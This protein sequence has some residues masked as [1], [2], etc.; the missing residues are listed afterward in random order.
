MILSS[1]ANGQN[2]VTIAL[3]DAARVDAWMDANIATRGLEELRRL[4]AFYSDVQQNSRLIFCA[5]AG[6][7]FLGHIT[8]QNHSEYAAFRRCNIPEIVDLW[9]QPDAR[10]RGVGRL[11]LEKLCDHAKAKAAQTI[12]LAVGVTSDFGAAHRLYN[13]HGFRPDGSGLWVQGKNAVRGDH[14]R[15][16]DD[17]VLIWIKNLS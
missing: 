2:D 7:E 15:L 3:L 17:V 10:N 9:V 11:L 14:V 1:K 6:E 5:W 13:A 8:L 12:G 4:S 16:D